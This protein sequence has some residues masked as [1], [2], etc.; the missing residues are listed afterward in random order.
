[1]ATSRRRKGLTPRQRWKIM[2]RDGFKCVYCGASSEDEMLV[3]DHV[4]PVAR[5]GEDSHENYHTACEKC[6]AGKR[7]EPTVAKQAGFASMEPW[8][9][10][11]S[12][13]LHVLLAKEYSSVRAAEATEKC[14][15]R[16]CQAADT[17]YAWVNRA[18]GKLPAVKSFKIGDSSFYFRSDE[19]AAMDSD[20]CYAF[21][22]RAD[23][24]AHDNLNSEVVDVYVYGMNIIDSPFHYH[25]GGEEHSIYPAQA[26]NAVVHGYNRKTLILIGEPMCFIGFHV[27]RRHKGCGILDVLDQNLNPSG[28]EVHT[29]YIDEVEYLGESLESICSG[30][31]ARLTKI[32]VAPYIRSLA[33][34]IR[35][36]L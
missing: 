8:G 36:G 6:N 29:A 9:F 23:Y 32:S 1:M 13:W 12:D 26:I 4:D 28:Q 25:G 3:I 7:D 21:P 27:A 17:L 20:L 30:G 2:K 11:S 18:D 5:G 33:E 31:V 14:S 19:Q 15:K 16:F 34:R 24:V 35:N 10:K 22:C